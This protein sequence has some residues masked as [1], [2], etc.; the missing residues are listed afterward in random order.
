MRERLERLEGRY[1]VDAAAQTTAAHRA[2]IEALVGAV[3]D[4]AWAALEECG[5]IEL[6]DCS[7]PVPG[8]LAT[9]IGRFHTGEEALGALRRV[10]P[11]TPALLPFAASGV[12]RFMIGLA[13]DLAL[14]VLY[15]SSDRLAAA[16]PQVVAPTI[17][18]FI[19]AISHEPRPRFD[20]A[21][22][23]SIAE[24]VLAGGRCTL[25]LTSGTPHAEVVTARSAKQRSRL[26]PDEAQTLAAFLTWHSA[27]DREASAPLPPFM[28]P[29]GLVPRPRPAPRAARSDDETIAAWIAAIDACQAPETLTFMVDDTYRH[30]TLSLSPRDGVTRELGRI[31]LPYADL[32]GRVSA[33]LRWE[34][35][36][37]TIAQLMTQVGMRRALASAQRRQP[38]LA[39]VAIGANHRRRKV[40]PIPTKAT[41]TPSRRR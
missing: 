22:V 29:R 8:R 26:T 12:D 15:V 10:K 30:V 36:T 40:L 25:D 24:V 35:A 1:D 21:R 13:G 20:S 19:A 7:V 27:R 6:T 9:L 39:C 23:R 2:A 32:G 31:R 37:A 34:T 4:R 33:D 28:A 16:P 5:G 18:A 3:P 17:D 14:R 41:R 11:P 38:H